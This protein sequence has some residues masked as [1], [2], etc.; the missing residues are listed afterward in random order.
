MLYAVKV[1]YRVKIEAHSSRGIV[2]RATGM[3]I[4][5]VA[6]L[7]NNPDCSIEVRHIDG[8]DGFQL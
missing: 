8:A 7:L 3:E 5:E 2:W 4:E 6:S 1:E